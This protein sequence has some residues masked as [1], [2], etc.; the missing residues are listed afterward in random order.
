VNFPAALVG[1]MARCGRLDL[2]FEPPVAFYLAN[3]HESGCQSLENRREVLLCAGE[4]A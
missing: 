1:E 2:W 4:I 3:P